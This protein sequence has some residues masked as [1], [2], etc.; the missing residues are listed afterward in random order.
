M[1]VLTSYGIGE[2]IAV[3]MP[4]EDAKLRAST[5]LQDQPTPRARPQEMQVK[6]E[7]DAKNK[8]NYLGDSDL[9]NESLCLQLRQDVEHDE[10]AQS[11]TKP[12]RHER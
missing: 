8:K 11:T 2:K 7:K 10:C 12:P 3:V 9:S 6:V 1:T 5:S 4:L